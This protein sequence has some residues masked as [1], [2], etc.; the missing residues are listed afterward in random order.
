[1]PM[2]TVMEWNYE[3]EYIIP[4]MLTGCL[5]KWGSK[6]QSLGTWRSQESLTSRSPNKFRHLGKRQRITFIFQGSNS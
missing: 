1:M 6:I 4:P 5:P 2:C 3:S